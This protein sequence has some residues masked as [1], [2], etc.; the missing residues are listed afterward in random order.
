MLDLIV[1]STRAFYI[2][3]SLIILC[4]RLIPPFRDRFLAYGAR[5][6]GVTHGENRATTQSS[7]ALQV[8]NY[9]AI[10]KVPHSWFVHFYIVSVLSSIACFSISHS[11]SQSNFLDLATFSSILMLVQGTRR[12]LECLFVTKPSSSRMWIGHYAI[13]LAFYIVTNI[14]I[15]I[16]ACREDQPKTR[17]L[18]DRWLLLVG[19]WTPKTLICTWLFFYSSFKQNQYHRYLASLPK[20]TVPDEPIFRTTIAPHYL[21][22]CGIYL[23]LVLLQTPGDQGRSNC[24]LLCAFVFVI[25]NLGVTADETKKWMTAK[26]PER[27]KEISVRWRMIPLLW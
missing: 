16:E 4:V 9:V 21:A 11:G 26:F 17:P 13:G 19:F 14:A 27:R 10:W 3:S 23:S 7:L 18:S 25:V 8:L 6:P 15:R 12:L 22:E 5:D 20:Y 2:L 24:S 1:W